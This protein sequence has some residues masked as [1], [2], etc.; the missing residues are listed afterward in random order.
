MY[1]VNQS[2]IL[3]EE[4]ASGPA[5]AFCPSAESGHGEVLTWSS[6]EDGMY[7]SSSKRYSCCAV[8]KFIC[9]LVVV[10]FW[11]ISEVRYVW[12]MVREDGA[13]ER[14]DLAE[15]D[16][17]PVNILDAAHCDGR[18]LDAGADADVVEL[19]HSRPPSFR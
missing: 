13:W 7:S 15:C 1:F 19:N 5:A 14:V 17:M 11:E 12:E 16:W 8:C 10:D 6:P 2:G 4:A 18:S 9:F 3:V